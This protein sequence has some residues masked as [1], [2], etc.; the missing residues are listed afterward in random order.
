MTNQDWT[1]KMRSETKT[2]RDVFIEQI[3]NRMHQDSRIFFLSA[4]FGAP[5]LDRIRTD[6][7]NRFINVGI[8]EQNLIN[9]CT[10]LAL[11]GFTVYA[12][13]IAPFLTMRPYE[14]IRTNLSILSQLRKININ[15]V[16]VGIGLSYEV[17]GPTHYCL[18]DIG[19]MRMLPNILLFSPSDWVLIK[20]FAD[21]TFQNKNPKYIR[22]DSKPLPQIYDE[23]QYIKIED[24]FFEL[25]EGNN[26]CIISTGYMTHK[27]ISI[28]N[29]LEKEN[30]N[31]GVIDIF[32]LK[33]VDQ[34]LLFEA[35][36]KYKNII[37]L[38]ESF[39]NK[40]GLDSI[41]SG[42]LHDK[43]SNIKLRRMGFDDTHV[44]EVGG[45]EY[46]HRLYNLDEKSIID[47]IK[48]IIE[49]AQWVRK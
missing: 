15:L 28:R 8:A 46:L 31:I 27:A 17:S 48:E 13:G 40:G 36:K 23:N 25:F 1:L 41:V 37:T 44:F 24:G 47:N 35:L 9:I 21:Y 16:G 34:N 45:R 33:P 6:F 4:D 7:P 14:Q 20:K 12:Y 19:I 11:E 2:M 26:I 10:G 38:E 42:I 3:Y 43:N 49:G 30:I 22:L 5:M 18:E 32:L 29:L 39:I